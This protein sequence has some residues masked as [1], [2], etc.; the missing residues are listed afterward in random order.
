MSQ[1]SA[2]SKEQYLNF[3]LQNWL[4]RIKLQALLTFFIFI[5][6]YSFLE[7]YF[8]R[9]NQGKT[10]VFSKGRD[11]WATLTKNGEWGSLLSVDVLEDWTE[12]YLEEN[13][14][15]DSKSF[16]NSYLQSTVTLFASWGAP[17]LWL[18]DAKSQPIGKDPD[19]GKD[20]RQKEKSVAE[21]TKVR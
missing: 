17:I 21:D 20:W 5:W 3:Y 9:N 4:F 15:S 13:R 8:S 16:L 19:T 12:E 2:A 7:N 18:P 14:V 10:Q 1:C 6:N 11:S